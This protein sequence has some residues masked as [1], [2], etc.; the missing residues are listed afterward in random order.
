MYRQG[1]GAILSNAGWE[2]CF[3]F[4]LEQTTNCDGLVGFCSNGGTAGL[5][6]SYGGPSF[7]V[8]YS[9]AR[10]TNF[11]FYSKNTN[12]DYA[13]NDGSNYE[14]S[15]GVAVD[16][17]FHTVRI[18]STSAGNIEMKFDS[19]SWTSIA[20]V[21]NTGSSYFPIFHVLARTTAQQYLQA[22]FSS[23]LATGLSR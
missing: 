12:S 2:A 11:M 1:I 14:L 21:N 7:G 9:S 20:H 6:G 16:T 19:G 4:K 13:A 23:F 17:S 3:V 10:D 18:R 5:Y 8:R 22:D 15:T